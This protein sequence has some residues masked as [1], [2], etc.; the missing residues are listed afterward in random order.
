MLAGGFG[1]IL[2]A[3]VAGPVTALEQRA[4]TC[5]L[6]QATRVCEA[7]CEEGEIAVGGGCRV[8]PGGTLPVQALV[9]AGVH[10]PTRYTCQWAAPRQRGR[11]TVTT[12]VLCARRG[13]LL[14][15]K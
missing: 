4:L 13:V 6:E 1:P 11:T 3:L 2:A 7:L 10:E 12:F 8:E 5:T 14:T 9:G 15:P